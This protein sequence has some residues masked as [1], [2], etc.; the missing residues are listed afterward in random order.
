MLVLDTPFPCRDNVRIDPSDLGFFGEVAGPDLLG[1]GTCARLTHI[2]MRRNVSRP[3]GPVVIAR[4]SADGAS[5]RVNQVAEDILLGHRL[6]RQLSEPSCRSMCALDT[7]FL[8]WD[9]L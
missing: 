5:G 1:R 4:L 7:L 3:E 8:W 6:R 2:K 9:S